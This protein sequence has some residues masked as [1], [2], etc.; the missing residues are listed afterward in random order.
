[1]T[2]I[3]LVV[4]DLDGTLWS[5]DESIHPLALTALEELAQRRVPVV[6]ATGRN[7]RLARNVLTDHGLSLDAVLH[8]GAL[9]AT[10][11]DVVFHSCPFSATGVRQVVEVFASFGHEPMFETDDPEVDLVIGEH[12]SIPQVP[13]RST[14]VC[15]LAEELPLPGFRAIAAVEPDIASTLVAAIEAAGAGHAWVSPSQF[16]DAVWIL[17]RP[18]GCSKWAAVLSYCELVGA[19]PARVLA[20][21]DGDN[22][23]ELLA[24]ARVAL[25]PEGGSQSAREQAHHLI[26][27]ASDGGW[28]QLLHFM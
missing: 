25:A 4:T 22:D 14:L 9:G 18:P 13:P 16:P 15:N 3:E 21:G 17:A 6:V 23:I 2:T 11:S 1:V 10:T 12:P 27:A 8:D 24:N 28:A 5:P 20:I 26:P 19:D 7:R